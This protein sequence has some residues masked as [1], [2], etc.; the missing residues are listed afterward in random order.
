M[1]VQRL[2]L[3]PDGFG[4]WTSTKSVVGIYW[5]SYKQLTGYIDA[6]S[7]KRIH[8]TDVEIIMRRK[9]AELLQINDVFSIDDDPTEYRINNIFQEV[10]M[11]WQKINATKIDG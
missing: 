10:E 7:G 5:C 11:W 6:K 2:T 9:T 8:T 1:T 3:S 4:G